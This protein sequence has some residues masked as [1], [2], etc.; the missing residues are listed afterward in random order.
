MSEERKTPAETGVAGEAQKPR[1]AKKKGSALKTLLKVII[2][3]AVIAAV[4]FATL[5]L[6]AKIGHF[7]SIPALIDYI[8]AQV[9]W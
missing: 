7:D 4:I 5:F 9:G 3:L 6:S 1:Q 8:R 2:W